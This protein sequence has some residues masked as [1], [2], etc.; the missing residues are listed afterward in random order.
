[1]SK[2]FPSSD[3]FL[4]GTFLGFGVAIVLIFIV[5]H[6][7]A[8]SPVADVLPTMLGGIIAGYMVARRST[9]NHVIIG[10]LIGV[11][12]FLMSTLFVILIIRTIEGLL[13][14]WLGFL[15]GGAIGG[16]LSATVY[17]RTSRKLTNIKPSNSS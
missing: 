14:M 2:R 7:G 8:V 5:A 16:M 15:V 11:S 9:H 13:W 4:A 1:V 17:S 10:L 12:S 6:V 3:E